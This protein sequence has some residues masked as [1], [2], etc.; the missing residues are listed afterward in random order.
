MTWCWY[1]ETVDGI[2]GDDV[3][4]RGAKRAE[5]EIDIGDTAP[6]LTVRRTRSRGKP[7]LVVLK[8]G[9]PLDLSKAEIQGKINAWIGLDFKSFKNS[10]LYGQGDAARFASPRTKDSERKD[11]L[12]RIANT[13]ILQTCHTIALAKRSDL[14]DEIEDVERQRVS[15]RERLE[16]IDL[17]TLRTRSRGWEE[18]RDGRVAEYQ[19]EVAGLLVKAQ[20]HAVDAGKLPD[21]ERGLKRLEA[22]RDEMAGAETASAQ[23]I[24]ALTTEL[25]AART[26]WEEMSRELAGL[27][28][29]REQMAKQISETKGVAGAVAELSERLEEREGEQ[30]ETEEAIAGCDAELS[31]LEDTL[32]VLRGEDAVIGPEIARVETEA[33]RCDD[34]LE[35]LDGDRC[36]TCTTPLTEGVAAEY[37]SEL[38]RNRGRYNEAAVKLHASQGEITRPID[39]TQK[40]L[41]GA[42]EKARQLRTEKGTLVEHASGLKASLAI[43]EGAVECL[44]GLQEESD[45]CKGRGEV[46]RA[47]LE[48][49]KFIGEERKEALETELA[50]AWLRQKTDRGRYEE[51]VALTEELA[52]ARAAA[53]SVENLKGQARREMERLQE[54]IHEVNPWSTAFDEAE[55]KAVE[56]RA[57]RATLDKEL[58]RLENELAHVVF[59][60]RGFGNE[61]LPSFV[62]DSVVPYITDRTNHYLGVLA[63]GDISMAFYTQRELKSRDGVKDEITIDW[64]IEGQG[65]VPPSGGQLRKMEIASDLAL[66]DLV[67]TREGVQLDLLLLD[68]VLDGLDREG[69]SRVLELLGELRRRRGSVFVISHESDLAEEFERV[70]RVTKR[71]GCATV[72][73]VK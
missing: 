26:R 1:G 7:K 68:E 56:Y 35:R 30:R 29:K 65:R 18:E 44:A 10:V 51:I 17:D 58:Q 70:V 11:M 20:E 32:E 64:D 42:K 38:T 41:N 16:E 9:K 2:K 39:A 19:A 24:E 50:K 37:I 69:R 45:A 15:T 63:D 72:E 48:E 57:R 8:D 43:A 46:L 3:I 12:H 21:L 53:A 62:L 13:E 25:D 73:V 71:N 52:I 40:V 49:L 6:E 31:S 55:A 28:A 5:V 47:A 23:E 54:A 36:P 61:G 59:W 66:M 60:V 34:E 27:K 67:A 4:R 33:K 22:E 14:Q